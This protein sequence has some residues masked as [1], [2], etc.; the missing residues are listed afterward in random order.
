MAISK[1][2][3]SEE[4]KASI[5]Y[6]NYL[7][8]S[9]GTQQVKGQSKGLLTRKGEGSG[10]IPKVPGGPSDSSGSSSSESKDED[11][12]LSTDDKELEDQSDDERTKTGG[13]EKSEEE[14]AGEEQCEPEETVDADVVL[15]RLTRLEKKVA[16]MSNIDHTEAIKKSV[17]ANVMNEVKNQLP[18]FLPKAVSEY[19]SRSFLQHDKHLELYNTL[20]GSMGIDEAIA[21]GDLDPTKTLKKIHRDDDQDPHADSKK[22]KKKRRQKDTEPSKKNNNQAGSKKGKT[23]SKPSKSNK[24]TNTKELVQDAAMDDEELVQD[25]A[26][27]A[28]NMTQADTIHKQDNSKWFKQ[29]VVVRPKT[30]DPDWFKEPN[31]NDAPEQNWFNELVNAEKDP[32][33]SDDLMSSTVDFNKYAKQCLKKDYITKADLEGPTFTLLKGNF[34]NNIELE[35]NMEHCYLALT[36]QIDLANSEGDRCPYDLSNYSCGFLLQ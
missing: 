34:K 15:K 20:I 11:G 17:Q 14:K 9:M 4:I 25:D 1:E 3:I 36:D 24:P 27:D 2:M 6:S 21:E 31:A 8:K 33:T 23:P 7:A 12:F 22:E 5:D 28:D 18:K 26:M 16:A 10:V 32:V 35:Y 29:D 30:L 19:I 13:S